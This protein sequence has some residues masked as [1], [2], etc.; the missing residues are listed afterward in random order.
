MP[1]E[2]LLLLKDHGL[3]D[4]TVLIPMLNVGCCSGFRAVAVAN[5][6]VRADPT[7]HAVLIVCAEARSSLGNAMPHPACADDKIQRNALVQAALFRDGASAAIIG[8]A[9]VS[10]PR[11][12]NTNNSF[13]L[14]PYELAILKHSTVLIP[15]TLKDGVA[16]QE[17]DD[18]FILVR[19]IHSIPKVAAV[20]G[21]HQ[22]SE[23]VIAHGI[24]LRQCLL[25]FHPASYAMIHGIVTLLGFKQEQALVS[26]DCVR[27]TGNIGGA[28]NLYI[29]DRWLRDHSEVLQKYKYAVCVAPAAGIT[30]QLVLC[31]IVPAVVERKQ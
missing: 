17:Q 29:V 27:N 26:Y 2:G 10:L 25:F 22:I 18:N 14:L 11:A 3:T 24:D 15:G 30:L 4:Q 7:R 12:F 9:A 5:D 28:T 1:T 23:T 31:E 13:L 8:T 20:Y 19:T 21:V 6:L 16:T